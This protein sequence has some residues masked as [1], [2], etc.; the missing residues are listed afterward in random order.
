MNSLVSIII[1]CR[2]EEKFIASCLDS[3]F[4]QTFPKESLEVLVVDG[5]SEDRTR[6]IA[7]RYSKGRPWVKIYENPKKIFASG[8]NV[9]V[10]LAKGEFVVIWGAHATYSV[11]YVEECVAYL[12]GYADVWCVGGALM[13]TSAADTLVARAIVLSLGGRFGKGRER[14]RSPQQVD[15]VFGGCYRRSVFE[16]IGL[17]DERLERSADMDFSLR[18]IRG[19]G[20]IYAIPDAVSFYYPKPTLKE[21]FLHNMKDGMWVTLPFKIT[22]RPFK[23]R[24][25][26]PFLF[27][28]T[29]PVS[30][31]LYIP[32]VLFF[33]V[34][35]AFREKDIRFLLVM[36]LAFAS[37]HFGYG[38]GSVKGVVESMRRK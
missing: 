35:I 15:T 38:L 6:S 2:N 11:N 18:I 20:K 31:L 10:R 26:L 32:T 34:K 5:M 13:P 21:F 27:M 9:G 12:Q 23:A 8:V 22:R 19:G 29:F 17:Y 7:E 4:Q 14:V 28:L 3:A 36:P 24:H 30:I 25:Y 37:R 16:N 33:S 1:V